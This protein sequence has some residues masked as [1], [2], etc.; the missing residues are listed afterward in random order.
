MEDNDLSDLEMA[1]ETRKKGLFLILIAM[2]FCKGN[3]GT[4]LNTTHR[5]LLQELLD[6]ND[7]LEKAQSE[8]SGGCLNNTVIVWNH[9]REI[10]RGNKLEYHFTH[11]IS[12]HTEFS[13]QVLRNVAWLYGAIALSE[14]SDT[15]S[16][17]EAA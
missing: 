11:A 16:G 15:L 4:G 8:M 2:E 7:S 6:L 13:N 1:V 17:K 9:H 10:A 14:L 12:Q 5:N 3:K